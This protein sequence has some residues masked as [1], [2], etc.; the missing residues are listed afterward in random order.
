MFG[1][2]VVIRKRNLIPHFYTIIKQSGAL[3]AKGWMLGIQFDELFSDNL[4]FDIARHANAEAER[5]RRALVEKG[6]SLHIDCPTN[7]I[8]VALDQEQEQRMR[9]ATTFSEWERLADG[10]LVVRLATSWAT[11]SE[12]VDALIEQL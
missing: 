12:D 5:L 7:Q 2:A 3:L 1:E 11:R 10:R 4:Y 8:F 9:Q 6:Y